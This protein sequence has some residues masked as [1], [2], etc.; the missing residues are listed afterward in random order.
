V[1]R[2]S[3]LVHVLDCATEE[4]CRDPLTDLDV[5]EAELEQYKTSLSDRPRLVVL[6]KI[7][8]PAA[9]DLADL[10]RPDLEERGLR[11]F[12]LSA[13]T[14]EGMRELS[15]ALAEVVAA[16]RAAQ[17]IEEATR[18]VLRPTAVDDLGFAVHREGDGFVVRGVKPERWVVQTDFSNDEAVGYLAD[19][20]A[21]LGVE[22]ALAA[23]GATP[24]C[25]VTIGD[26]TFDWEPT[27]LEEFASGMRGQDARFEDDSRIGATE[28]RLQKDL[29]RA[30]RM[31][32]D[33]DALLA[34]LDEQ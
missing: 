34:Q 2:C 14:R 11:V 8:V 31:G 1:E 10:V 17:P 27:E 3:V 7:D 25:E 15:F 5:I 29:R 22:K 16:H 9:R 19:R 32:L 30:E 21:R 24:G 28:R 12:A 26:V 18:I 6:N 20:L 33:K 13:A 4:P 23:A